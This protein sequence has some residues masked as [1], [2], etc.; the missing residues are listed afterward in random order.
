MMKNKM[1]V[2]LFLAATMMIGSANAYAASTTVPQ[3]KI[4]PVA[5]AA[6]STRSEKST[7]S[8]EDQ[9]NELSKGLKPGQTIAYYAADKGYNPTDQIYFASKGFAYDTYSDYLSKAKTMNAPT[10]TKPDALPKGY[11]FKHGILYL[12]SPERTSDLYKKLDKELKAEA[13]KGGKT[14]YTKAVKDMNEATAAVLKY[15]KGKVKIDVIA[16]N[17]Y[18]A[19]PMDGIPVPAEKPNEKTETIVINGVECVYTDDSTGRDHL[20]WVDEEH[21]IRYT[22]WAESA[23]SDVLSFAKKMLAK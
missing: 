20:D 10:L 11:N 3:A 7:S 19:P 22:I 9:I 2:A 21:Q 14:L 8:L 6:S 1:K 17:I 4:K 16:T 15:E 5:A 23:K 13:A 12:K 18:P